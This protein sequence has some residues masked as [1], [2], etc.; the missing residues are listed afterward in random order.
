MKTIKLTNREA[1]RLLALVSKALA[2]K[3]DPLLLA[4]KFELED[5]DRPAKS[6]E[7]PG[8]KT[9]ITGIGTGRIN[10]AWKKAWDRGE[11]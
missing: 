6:K 9:Q 5:L 10:P 7:F 3:P 8:G 4:V 11:V 1:A 2:A